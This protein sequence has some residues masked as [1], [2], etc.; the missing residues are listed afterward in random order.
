MKLFSFLGVGAFYDD[1]CIE[2]IFGRPCR[3][4]LFWPPA[5]AFMSRTFM[6]DWRIVGSKKL[7]IWRS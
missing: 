5:F 1:G 3:L 7:R 2:I 4:L 6:L